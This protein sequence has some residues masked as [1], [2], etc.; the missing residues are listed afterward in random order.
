MVLQQGEVALQAPQRQWRGLTIAIPRDLATQV[1]GN[2][3]EPCTERAIAA[4]TL[5]HEGAMSGEK[6]ILSHLF[7]GAIGTGG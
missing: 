4:I 3:E 2:A 5:L 6:D 1:A 7:R